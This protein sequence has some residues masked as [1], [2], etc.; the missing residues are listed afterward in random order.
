[1]EDSL[2]VIEAIWHGGTIAHESEFVS[3]PE[4]IFEATPAQRP[5]PP[6]YLAAYSSAG[7]ARIAARADGWTPAG[8]P[9]PVMNEMYTAIKAMAEAG[10][11]DPDEIGLVVRANC[12][13]DATGSGDG[14]DVFT[15][16]IDQIMDDV[17][18]CAEIGADE[19]FIE[20]QYS[21]EA[22]SFDTYLDY[23]ERFSELTT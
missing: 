20:V 8:L 11:R 15:G 16:S 1:M 23:M 4:S 10:G 14:R 5:R 19:V 7:L 21:P 6:I 13:I 17:H 18:Q 2:D 9:V 3:M 12:A 22:D